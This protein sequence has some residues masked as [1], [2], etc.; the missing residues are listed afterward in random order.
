[1]LSSGF[2]PDTHLTS[3]DVLTDKILFPDSLM[4]NIKKSK[5]DQFKRGFTIV[6]GK[7]DSQ[8]CPIAAI[9]TY[10]HLR[11]QEN[12]PMFIFKDGVLLARDKFSRLVNQTVKNAGWQGNFSTHSFRVGAA[13]TAVA[14]DVPDQMIRAMGR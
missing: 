12:G 13:S 6:L 1:M 2:L 10:L 4:I 14:L 9:L 11:G 7:T 5:T 8:I 3:S